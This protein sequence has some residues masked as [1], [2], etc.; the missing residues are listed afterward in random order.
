MGQHKSRK[1]QNK[2]WNGQ[3]GTRQIKRGQDVATQIN[4]EEDG[5]TQIEKGY[6]TTEQK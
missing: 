6:V 5:A 3:H 4:M 2:V 1:R